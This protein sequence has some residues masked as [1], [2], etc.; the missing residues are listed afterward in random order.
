MNTQ[1]SKNNGVQQLDILFI[2]PSYGN[3]AAI[4][5]LRPERVQEDIPNQE[6]PN[7][8]IGYLLAQAKR[9]GIS[10]KYIDMVFNN[11]SVED[12]VQFVADHRP[13][14]VAF[15]AFTP[16]IKAAG[17]VADKIKAAFPS[18]VIGAGG[19]HASAIPIDTLNE[20]PSFDFAYVGEAEDTLTAILENV[21]NV[22]ALGKVPGVV[23]RGQQT[24]ESAWT[25]DLD[26]LAFP[27]WEEFDLTRYGGLSPHRTARELPMLAQRGCPYKCNF[28]MRASGDT[29]RMRSVKSV[30]AEIEHNIED[31]GCESISFL[32]ETFGLNKK[33]A[34]EL[35]SAFRKRG[36]NKKIS[37]ACSTRVSHTTPE[38]MEAFSEAGCYY[39]FFG[40]E[41]AD[42]EVL[43]TTGKKI[44]TD[45]MLRTVGWAKDAGIV[46]VGAF[47]IGLPD[48]K[49]E[50]VFKSID[51][52]DQ[53]NLFSVTFPI[54]VPFP[55]TDLYALAKD[56]K[57]GMEIL[58]YDWD[59]YGKQE[60]GVLES[61]DISWSRRKELQNIAYERHPKKNLDAY[62]AESIHGRM[63]LRAG[64]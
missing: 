42:S 3:A 9:D 10:A 37:W 53:L 6:S 64:E 26:S 48:E 2:Y 49:E 38:L 35:F 27:A 12:V 50:G 59:S 44:T 22:N 15:T 1:D 52:A 8:G 16:H 33:W 29:V 57:H 5:R 30:V 55:G 31:F 43:L 24:F 21:H 20:F 34:K 40:F 28:C 45:D 18:T 46:P 19:V 61:A 25:K 63:A 7:I 17:H 4:A 36:L 58:S 51:F 56:G 47:I 32:D 13:T 41:S 11:Y 62:I 14:L 54:A 39:T 23:I 60:G